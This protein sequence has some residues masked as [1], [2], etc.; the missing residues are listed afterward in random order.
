MRLAADGDRVVALLV[1]HPLMS[2]DDQLVVLLSTD[3]GATFSA[4]V[5]VHT[6]A[7]DAHDPE[8]VVDGDDIHLSWQHPQAGGFG[9][10][11]MQYQ[12]SGDFGQTWLSTAIDAFN[13]GLGVGF[14]FAAKKASDP[15]EEAEDLE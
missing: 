1:V 14:F 7:A 5:V 13:V 11:E 4:P 10:F 3:A 6:S 12:H 2:V 15:D 8:V 9:L